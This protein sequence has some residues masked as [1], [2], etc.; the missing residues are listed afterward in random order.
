MSTGQHALVI[1][2]NKANLRVLATL[3]MRQGLQCTEIS[4]SRQLEAKL[5]QLG[6]IDLVFL[7]LEM[8]G[9]N[10]YDAKEMLRA[11]LGQTPIIAYTVHV[12][13]MNTTRNKGFDGFIGKPLDPSRFPNQLAR[14]LRHEGVWERM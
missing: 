3:L 11:H 13:E 6:G 1:D 8:P 14:I 7:D 4:D 5:P 10:G 2:D 9:V 12:S